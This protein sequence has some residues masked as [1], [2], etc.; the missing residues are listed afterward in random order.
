MKNLKIITKLLI[1][2]FIPI[3]LMI[4]NILIDNT[5]IK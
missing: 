2:F 1:V 5:A 4:V 3:L